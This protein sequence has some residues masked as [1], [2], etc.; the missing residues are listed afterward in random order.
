MLMRT[1]ELNCPLRCV[2]TSARSAMVIL[3]LAGTHLRCINRELSITQPRMA[4]TLLNLEVRYSSRLE[5]CVPLN[6]F[7]SSTVRRRRTLFQFFHRKT[8]GAETVTVVPE[9]RRNEHGR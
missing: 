3:N 4:G 9:F 5:A 8:R 1:A 2:V 7:S 6:S